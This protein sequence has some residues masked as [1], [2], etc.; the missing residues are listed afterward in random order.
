MEIIISANEKILNITQEN[1]LSKNMT[2]KE[3]IEWL[4]KMT[5]VEIED[6]KE[7]QE[8]PIQLYKHF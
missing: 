3:Y 2:E 4:N 1:R 7:I 6:E 5:K 8:I